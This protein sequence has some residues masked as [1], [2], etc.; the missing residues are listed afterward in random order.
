M[1]ILITGAPGVGKTTL[2]RTLIADCPTA[3]GFYTE[4]IRE[5]HKRVGFAIK[6]LQGKSGILAHVTIH[7]PHRVSRYGVNVSH[8]KD[9][10][11]PSMD[12][13]GYPIVIDEIGKM[14]LV[15]TPFRK[16]VL[17]ALDTCKVLATIME[18]SHP[19]TDAIKKRED[20]QLYS[21]TRQNREHL[22][23][24]LRTHLFS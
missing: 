11:I 3:T 1:N 20:T 8:I 13:T 15:S 21:V 19:F 23:D 16:Q 10:C 24:E 7:G 22:C 6:T 2:I 5:D 18:R 14:E 4:E 12:L 17:K 9:I